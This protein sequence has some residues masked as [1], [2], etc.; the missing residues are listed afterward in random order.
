MINMVANTSGI[1]ALAI[2]SVSAFILSML[3]TPLYTY[4]AYR[5]KFWKRKRETATT[6]EKLTV[7]AKQQAEKLEKYSNYGRNHLFGSSNNHYIFL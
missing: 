5:F 3:L 2:L 4:F 1:I 6:G 7:F